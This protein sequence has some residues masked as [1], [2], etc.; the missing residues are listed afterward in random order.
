MIVVAGT[1]GSLNRASV[2]PNFEWIRLAQRIP[3]RIALERVPGNVELA[4]GMSATVVIRP[5]PSQPD[6]DPT[7]RRTQ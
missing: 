3:V 1:D 7:G 6:V 4:A 5:P 2:D